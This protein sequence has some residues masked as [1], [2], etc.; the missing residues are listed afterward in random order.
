MINNTPKIGE[1]VSFVTTR[2]SGRSFIMTSNRGKVLET[3]NE[4]VKP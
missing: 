2:K 1:E 3:I 4:Q